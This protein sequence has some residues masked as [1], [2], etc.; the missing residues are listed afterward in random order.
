MDRWVDVVTLKRSGETVYLPNLS[1]MM[2]KV[3]GVVK[4]HIYIQ[5]ALNVHITMP[6]D[7]SGSP[8]GRM[9]VRPP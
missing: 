6:D 4:Y 9:F 8:L 2:T 5:N 1:R 3:V 7:L